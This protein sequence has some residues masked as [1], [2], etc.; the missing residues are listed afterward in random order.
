MFEIVKNISLN[1][2]NNENRKNELENTV[3]NI[4]VY[5]AQKNL[6]IYIIILFI[7]NF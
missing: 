7:K 2:S 1:I 6:D 4:P 5:K 3:R